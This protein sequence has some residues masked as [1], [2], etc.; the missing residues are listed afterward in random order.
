[1]DI[2]YNIQMINLKIYNNTSMNGG[3]FIINQCHN[4]SMIDSVMNE[5]QVDSAGAG[6][7][8]QMSSDFDL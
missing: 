7:F 4:I 1:M 3:G 5:N 6:F 8:I 2:S